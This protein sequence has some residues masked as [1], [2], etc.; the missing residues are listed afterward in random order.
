M[1]EIVK[2]GL[3]SK[4]LWQSFKMNAVMEDE[5]AGKFASWGKTY[6]TDQYIYNNLKFKTVIETD[7]ENSKK[8]QVRLN[9]SNQT[10]K[11]RV[12]GT[13]EV[14]YANLAQL[15]LM[16]KNYVVVPPNDRAILEIERSSPVVLI[17]GEMSFRLKMIS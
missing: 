13:E 4:A 12:E 10:V 1:W 14:L 9:T 5:E 8:V 6:P 7:A 2:E 16:K 11:I 17:A 15:E 3:K